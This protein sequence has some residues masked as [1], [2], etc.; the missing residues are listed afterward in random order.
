MGC[1]SR[2][3]Q[4][5]ERE[6]LKAQIEARKQREAAAKARARE[7]EMIHNQGGGGEGRGLNRDIRDDGEGTAG[8]IEVDEELRVLDAKHARELANEM[9]ETPNTVSMPSHIPYSGSGS[10]STDTDTDAGE[11]E[12]EGDGASAA[13]AGVS[14]QLV[15]FSVEAQYQSSF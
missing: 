12:G 2:E 13:M 5:A 15:M 1:C 8:I 14:A 10:S 11:G 6:T 7:T 9:Q 4:R 3:R